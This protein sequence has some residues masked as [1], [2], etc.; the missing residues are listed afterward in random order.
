M[1]L[2]KTRDLKV[3]NIHDHIG[4]LHSLIEVKGTSY[5]ANETGAGYIRWDNGKQGENVGGRGLSLA[6]ISHP[7]MTLVE[8][9]KRYDVYA[10]DAEKTNLAN[11]LK[12]IHSNEFGNVFYCLSSFDAIGTNSDLAESMD[13]VRANH[14][15]NLP[16][17]SL[18]PTHRHPYAAIG[19]SALGIIREVLHTNTSGADAAYVS[20]AVPF[21]WGEVGS[22][23]YG[24]DLDNGES[25]VEINYDGTGYGFY[26]KYFTIPETGRASLYEG[27]YVRMTGQH[28]ISRDR[29]AAGGSVRSYFWSA[30]DSDGWIRSASRDSKSVEWETFD[31][32]FMWSPER[33][34]ASGN[35]TGGALAKYLRTGHYH[36]TSS[37]DEGIS[38]IR[39]IQIQRCGMHP[40]SKGYASIQSNIL[41]GQHV[42]EHIGFQLGNP[43]SYYDL[44]A[45][46]KNLTNRPNLGDSQLGSGFDTE[47]VR[48][49]NRTLTARNEYSIHEGKNL[50]GSSNRYSD[51]GYVN[52][53]S[54]K[55][56]VGLIWMNCQEKTS[57]NNYLG[58]H[59]RSNGSQVPTYAYSGTNNTTN[60]YS[61]YPGAGSVEKDK[62]SLMAYW[63]L[64]H[65][66]TDAQGNEFYTKHWCRAFGNYEN[67]SADNNTKTL[68]SVGA[69]GGNIRVSRFKEGDDQIHLRWL[70]YYNGTS[71][72]KTWWA[73]PGIYEVD[74]FGITGVLGKSTKRGS[75]NAHNIIED[76]E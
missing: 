8:S 71:N 65:W 60:P 31:Y 72:H 32:Y 28:K 45:S 49:F 9:I 16:D 26:H 58:T 1:R 34:T 6:I 64:P 7:E 18:G 48:W 10:S 50:T 62:W 52:I 39:N 2:T 70:D 17:L 51:I 40:Y 5:N 30:S 15:F 75:V 41:S 46:P 74:P 37:I 53:D 27:E 73:L 59:T 42:S 35:N 66:F 38:S 47:Q 21:T 11:K 20:Y 24:P 29:F 57:G 14:W 25:M 69:N 19:T 22:E 23:G 44:W 63:F 54:N 61:H 13:M 43:G 33:D 3:N 56:Y 55:M 76:N 4:A 67:G 68:G 12:A 36:M